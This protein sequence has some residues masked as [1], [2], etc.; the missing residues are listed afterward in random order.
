MDNIKKLKI[1][2]LSPVRFHVFYL[3]R[4]LSRAGYD[5][6][7]YT[8]MPISK[9]TKYG[10]PRDVCIS[11]FW[12]LS[13]F[14]W[15][16]R[17]FKNIKSLSVLLKYIQD[18]IVGFYVRKCDICISTSGGFSH[19]IARMKRK[20]TIVIVHRGSKHI[21]EQKKIVDA[22]PALHGFSQFRNTI[23]K[24]ELKDYFN[25]DYVV[26]QTNHVKDSF[27]KQGYPNDK[28][29]VIPTGV[30]INEF[31]PSIG[32]TKKYDLIMVGT[33]CYRKGCDLIADA[34][35]TCGLKLLH[36]GNIGDL[37]FP[38]RP[39]LTH[40]DA[41][42]QSVL[43]SFYHQSKI[44][45]LPSREEGLAMV[46]IQALAC[47]LPIISSH[48]S[49]AEDLKGMVS[50]PEEVMVQYEKMGNTLYAGESL[51]NLT[52]E[53]YGKRYAAFLREKVRK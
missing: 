11:V 7:F 12:Q 34:V 37:K 53:A 2:I 14:V 40:L 27:I 8:C 4:E 48:D 20:G 18:Y 1:N 38:D 44:F 13:P 15:L 50:H 9:A 5:V 32:T 35:E 23:I 43:P 36:V 22:N 39:Y 26:V 52:W 24:R 19:T 21:L 51:K 33:W 17:F 3:A 42:E 47:N 31:T 45:I 41:V 46:L 10:M 29:S 30:D 16:S 49:G 6:K 25:A 28:I